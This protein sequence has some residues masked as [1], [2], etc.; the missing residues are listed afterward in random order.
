MNILLKNNEA[1]ELAFCDLGL[2]YLAAPLRDAGHD[3]RLL[4]TP[5]DEVGFIRLVRE[6]RPDVIGIKVLSSGV[7]NTVRTIEILRRL[8]PCIIVIGGPHVTG[9]PEGCLELMSADYAFQGE[10]DRSFPA[11]IQ[12]L[13]DGSLVGH[14]EEIAGLI[15]QEDGR[16][17]VNPPDMI[18]DIDPL[19]LPAWE[20]MP[21]ADHQSL[22]SRRTPA[23][24]MIA[25]RGCTDSCTFCV[26]GT[27]RLRIRSVASVMAEIRLLVDN[28][29]VRE[30]QFLD[31]NFVFSKK[32]LM[33][34]G[35]AILDAGLEV[36]FCAPNGTRLE[37]IDDDVAQMLAKIGFYRANIGIESG[38][39]EML[40]TLSKRLDL[41]ILPE[42]IALLRRH[43]ILV[44]GNFMLGFPDETVEQMRQSLEL[45]LKLDLT[46]ANFA[47]Y[48]PLPGTPLY[49][50]LVS[51]K[52][53]PGKS[54]FQGYNYVVYR[55]DLS[56]L[57]P[58]ALRR[59]RFWCMFRF[60]ARPRTV[61]TLLGLFT[62]REMRRSLLKRIYG[63]YIQKLLS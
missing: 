63:M 11:F 25:S 52:L 1:D 51:K 32:Y 37:A 34:L 27:R 31:S 12:V 15:W 24:P 30:I 14:R 29:G 18:R 6:Y 42:K 3:V 26:E 38:S 33:E 21:P 7:R 56:V 55:N 16:V 19:P 58:S 22:V 59:F 61:M 35:Q 20:L 4:L 54:R 2:G 40:K 44:V 28:Y 36:V 5:C 46:G 8:H 17:R 53:L 23:A 41:D 10:A 48:T 60:L 39:G 45:A 9:D 62:D 13:S 49:A 57:S 43:G 50:G 47:I